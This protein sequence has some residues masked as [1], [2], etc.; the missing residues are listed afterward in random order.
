MFFTDSD[1][2]LSNSDLIYSYH[3]VIPKNCIFTDYL[4]KEILGSLTERYSVIKKIGVV[5]LLGL[6]FVRD[7]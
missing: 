7:V 2:V 6:W 5:I 4:G 1:T 3:P